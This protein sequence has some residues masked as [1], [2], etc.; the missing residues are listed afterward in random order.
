M[1]NGLKH[2]IR[3]RKTTVTTSQVRRFMRATL[4][5]GI[6]DKSSV[7]ESLLV[8]GGG[9]PVMEPRNLEQALQNPQQWSLYNTPLHKSASRGMPFAS[10]MARR[11]LTRVP[12][13]QMLKS[14]APQA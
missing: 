6:A 8:R 7:L 14:G 2:G 9:G 3:P 4:N 1:D 5:L 12:Q 11:T 10:M 13:T